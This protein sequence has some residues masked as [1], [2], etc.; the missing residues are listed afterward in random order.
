MNRIRAGSTGRL[1]NLFDSQLRFPGAGRAKMDGLVSK[2]NVRRIDVSVRINGHRL[3]AHRAAG[4]HH[5]QSDLTPIRDKNVS[6]S[7]CLHPSS[8]ALK[9]TEIHLRDVL[10]DNFSV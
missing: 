6:K 8:M 4:A 9:L 3:N 10:E 1:D 2:S 5:T 7:P